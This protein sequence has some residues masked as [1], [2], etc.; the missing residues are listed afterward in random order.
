EPY[1]LHSAYDPN[2]ALD[3]IYEQHPDILFLHIMLPRP[4]P[5]KLSPQ[6]PK[7]YHMPII[8]LTPK[9]SQIH[10]LFPLQLPPHHYLTK[11]F[12]TRQLIPPLKPN[13]TP[14][15]PQP[16]QQSQGTTSQIPIKHIL[17]YP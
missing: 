12:T 11:P 6:L 14:H 8:I 16:P 10:K 5:M 7:K 3:L 9:H 15:Y 2:H 1:E 4:H 13:L 17:I